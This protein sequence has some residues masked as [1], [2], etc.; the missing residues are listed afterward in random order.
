M[1]KNM[2]KHFITITKHK[3]VVFKLCVK[4]GI[5]WRG[6]VHDLSK[7][8][9]TEFLESAKY[10]K[11]TY[12]PIQACKQENG[13]SQAWL[14][15]KGKNKHHLEYWYDYKAPVSMP[16]LPYTYTLEMIC[17]TL[18]AGIIYNGKNWNNST[19][20]EYWKRELQRDE[21]EP[22]INVHMKNLLTEVYEQ[23]SKEG[24]NNTLKRNNLKKIYEK[25]NMQFKNP[26]PPSGVSSLK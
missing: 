3:W 18:A 12:S 9:K 4:I 2:F 8:S 6:F 10:Y 15:H 22:K 19:Q 25:H 26:Q 21:K 5:P 14:H 23:V 1:I 24:I 13:Y 17:D 11:G 16:M 20:L 7:Y